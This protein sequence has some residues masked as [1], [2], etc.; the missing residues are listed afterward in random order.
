MDKSNK[1]IIA[2]GSNFNQRENIDY[3]QKHLS[4]ILGD[5]IAFSEEMWTAPIGIE[6]DKFINCL[7]VS[8]TSHTY[9]QTANALKHI[10]KKCG[11]TKKN[12]KEHKIPLDLDILLFGSEKF[13]TDDWN[14]EYVRKLIHNFEKE[15]ECFIL[16]PITR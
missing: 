6:S 8:A 2:I 7:C 10:E 15:K 16:D 12:D 4:L 13:H 1:L 11:R 3:A 9:T 5:S 14:R